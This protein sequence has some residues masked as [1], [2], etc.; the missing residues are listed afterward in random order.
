MH[1]KIILSCIFFLSVSLTHK[2]SDLKTYNLNREKENLFYL[3]TSKK[4][5]KSVVEVK[6]DGTWVFK[7]YKIAVTKIYK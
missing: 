4:N 3:N 5:Y 1:Y 6:I 2:A 7:N